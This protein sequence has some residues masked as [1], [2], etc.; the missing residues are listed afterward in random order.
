M[1]NKSRSSVASKL[2]DWIIRYCD[3]GDL[4]LVRQLIK[5]SKNMVFHDKSNHIEIRYHYIRDMMQKGVVRL[6]YVAMDKQVIDVLTN[7]LSRIKF[8]HFRGKLNVVPLQRE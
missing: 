2:V 5:L 6:Q 8:E 7:P 3:G 1:C 4:Y